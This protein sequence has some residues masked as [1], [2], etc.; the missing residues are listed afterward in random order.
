MTTVD[1]RSV[2]TNTS[3]DRCRHHEQSFIIRLMLPEFVLNGN[4]QSDTPLEAR[5][6]LPCN[7]TLFFQHESKPEGKGTPSS[8]LCTI[9]HGQ[10]VPREAVA[11]GGP[12]HAT[13]RGIEHGGT[14]LLL[15]GQ[16]GR[17]P[18]RP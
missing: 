8:V 15:Q 10:D 4:V 5:L 3:H 12:T 18:R 14:V 13:L 7:T 16:A 9:E 2:N 17:R 1:I 11:L 6:Q